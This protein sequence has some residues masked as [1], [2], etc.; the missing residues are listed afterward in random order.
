[1][2]NVGW[3]GI[4]ILALVLLLVFGPKKLPQVGRQLGRGMREFKDSVGEP[5]TEIKNALDTPRELREALSPASQL[6][7][8]LNPLKPLEDEEADGDAADGDV[9]EGEI[10]APA[11]EAAPA[12]KA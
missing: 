3:Q 5:A 2:G 6:K 1:M 10:V 4:L 11:A 7:D 9:L 8:A 12:P